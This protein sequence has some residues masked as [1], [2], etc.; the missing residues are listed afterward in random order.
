MSGDDYYMRRALA[1]AAKGQGRVEPNPMVGALVVRDGIVVG[2]G[3][4]QQFGGPHAEVHAGEMAGSEAQGATLYVTLEPCCHHG[5]TPPCVEAVLRAGIRKVVAAMVDPYPSVY[6]AGLKQL[7]Q[8][9]VEVVIGVEEKAAA[10]LNKPFI[11]LVTTGTPYVIAKWAMTLDGK[12][13]T[14]TGDSK[15]ISS[16]ASRALV[17]QLRG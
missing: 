14:R 13:A 4:H 11:K 1:L 15:W 8:A 6:G 16:V 7:E 9:G 2:Q 12:I 3:H 5:K 10:R 17:H